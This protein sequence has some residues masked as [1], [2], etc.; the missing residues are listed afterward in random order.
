MS[1]NFL[2]QYVQYLQSMGFILV[3][4]RPQSPARRSVSST[5]TG[6]TAAKSSLDFNIYLELTLNTTGLGTILVISQ[7]LADSFEEKEKIFITLQ[8]IIHNIHCHVIRKHEWLLHVLPQ[9]NYKWYQKQYE[10][11]DTDTDSQH[12][13][14]Y[15]Y[16]PLVSVAILDTSTDINSWHW[17]WYKYLTLI[18]VRKIDRY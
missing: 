10:I 11:I 3:Q 1:S 16:F 4:V 12:W 14:W 6:G 9:Y 17:Y 5:N 2:Q 13:Y 7:T 15:K 18:T 8:Y